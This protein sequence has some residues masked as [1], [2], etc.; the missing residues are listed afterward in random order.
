MISVT[1]RE[2]NWHDEDLAEFYGDDNRGYVHGIYYYEDGE[3]FPVDVQW[4]KSEDERNS[5]LKTLS[6]C[7]I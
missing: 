6:Q 2:V 5:V 7:E 4:F 3:D 1:Y